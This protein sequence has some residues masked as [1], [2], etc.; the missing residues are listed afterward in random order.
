MPSLSSSTSSASGMPSPSSSSSS[1][2]GTPSLSSSG[3]SSSGMPSPSRSCRIRDTIVVII[4]VLLIRNAIII[5]IRILRIRD[6]IAIVVIVQ[7]L[8]R[9][10]I[11]VQI[12]ARVRITPIRDTVVVI[13]RIET[14]RDTVA[15]RIALVRTVP[16]AQIQHRPLILIVLSVLLLTQPHQMLGRLRLPGVTRTL[17]LIV[18]LAG[19]VGIRQVSHSKQLT[20]PAGQSWQIPSFA[21]FS[22][23]TNAPFRLHRKVACG[24]QTS[25]GGVLLTANISNTY[26]TIEAMIVTAV[27]MRNRFP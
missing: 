4:H 19:L 7:L 9:D 27:R 5:V 22:C 1:V 3:S 10:A 12:I 23:T 24:A 8:V 15:V 21:H 18:L 2:S 13:V 6:A 16:A 11:A 17:E 20:F 14:V 26:S 25:G